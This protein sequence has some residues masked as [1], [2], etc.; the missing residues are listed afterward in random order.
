MGETV[1][2]SKILNVYDQEK[3]EAQL[4]HSQSIEKFETVAKSLYTLLKKRETAVEE[5]QAMLKSITAIDEITE[6][7]AYIESLQKEID[8][9]QYK[10]NAAR[11]T[12]VTKQRELTE[13]HVEVKK[14]EKIIELRNKTFKEKML[15]EEAQLMD[16]ISLQQY[17][18]Q[19]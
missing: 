6:R 17:L 15:K 1:V 19:K 13:A 12:M 11:Q 5:Y 14:Y 9:M 7:L 16:E 2:F 4:A 3:K 8:R 10:V 18:I